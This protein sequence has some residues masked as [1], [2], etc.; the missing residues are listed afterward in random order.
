VH[1]GARPRWL[2]CLMLLAPLLAGAA[3]E[4]SEYL[5]EETAATVTIVGAP[6]VFACERRDLAAHA[7]DYVTLAATAVSRNRQLDYYLVAYFWSTVAPHLRADALP[8]PPVLSLQADDRRIDLRR[9]V[10][11]ARA[12]GIST[13]VHPPPGEAPRPLLY[14]TD[15]ATLRFL[16]AARRL[17]VL[18]DAEA[19]PAGFAL[20]SDERAALRAFVLR[21]SGGR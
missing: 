14:P 21:M 8:S 4:P 11:S 5:D 15:L 12:A 19:T 2:A 3:D 20:W 16:A 17:K 6:L 1:A 7:R 9:S 18:S 13:G 10:L